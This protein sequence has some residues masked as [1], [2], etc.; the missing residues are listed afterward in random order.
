M[1]IKEFPEMPVD[2]PESPKTGSNEID[3]KKYH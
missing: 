1:V 3:S 2:A